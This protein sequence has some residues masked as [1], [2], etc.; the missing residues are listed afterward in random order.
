MSFLIDTHCHLNYEYDDGK[1]PDDLVRDS[2]ANGVDYLITIA[3]D[4]TNFETVQK[5]SEK[6]PNVFH[7][8]GV[9]PHDASTV[10]DQTLKFMRP[11]LDHP[12][13]VAVGEIGLDYYYEHSDR[14]KQQDECTA[15]AELALDARKPLVIHSR[16]GEDDLLKL[17]KNYAAKHKGG[18]SLGVIHCFSGSEAFARACIDLG[19]YI[20]LSGILTFKNSEPLRQMVKGFPI[21]RLLVETD[22]PFLAPVP[23]RGKKCEPFMV[24][25]TALKLAEVLGIGFDELASVTSK[26]ASSCFNLKI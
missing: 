15:Q 19:F 20:S 5:L 10:N 16:D 11:F 25:H 8:I 6:H 1:G 12:K 13:C 18:Y 21:D 26:N 17:L 23:L 7:T 9:H 14:K 22:S 4:H 3:T 2:K 24:K